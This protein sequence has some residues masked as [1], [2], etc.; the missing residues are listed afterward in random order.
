MALRRPLACAPHP[1][2]RLSG[3][4]RGP[5]PLRRSDRRGRFEDHGRRDPQS[6]QRRIQEPHAS[7]HVWR[8][9]RARGAHRPHPEAAPGQRA[10][11]GRRRLGS[12]VHV[13]AGHVRP[14]VRAVPGGDLKGLRRRGV[15]RRYTAMPPQGGRRKH[16]DDFSLLRRPGRDGDVPR[17]PQQHPQRGRRREP[18][19]PRGDGIDHRSLPRRVRQKGSPADQAEH[20]RPVRP[21]SAAESAHLPL[22]VAP[23][24]DVP[25]EAPAIP[26]HRQLLHHRLVHRVARRG[27]RVRR[28]MG[29]G[30]PERRRERRRRRLGLQGDAPVCGKQVCRVLGDAEAPQLRHAH[31]VP[32]APLVVLHAAGVQ[33]ARGADEEGPAAERAGQAHDDEDV[34]LEHAKG[35]RAA[36]APF[37]LKGGA[38]GRDDGQDGRGQDGGGSR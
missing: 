6:A 28:A 10:A 13:Q 17:G 11:F 36:P 35:A 29:A 31:L 12:A 2:L 34:G 14:W 16:A 25:G 9:H 21:P 37:D 1:L 3:P 7:G 26:V 15:A 24:R 30:S 23:R 4:R 8:C 5:A 38:S 18:V 19:R 20:L 22:H 32:R 27:S 33:T